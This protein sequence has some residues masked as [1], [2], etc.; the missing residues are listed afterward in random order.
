MAAYVVSKA[1]VIRLTESM[2]EELRPF[3]IN[4]NVIL[5]RNIDTPEN[6]AESPDA[7]FSKWVTPGA[8]AEVI[9][10]LASAVGRPIH[11]AS[12][13]VRGSG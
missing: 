7:D 9:V 8:I 12:I 11:G 2:A 5:P 10:F 4:V 6:R 3:N 1:A 13:P